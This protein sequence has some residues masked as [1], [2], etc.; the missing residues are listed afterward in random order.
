VTG[1]G[2][3][4]AAAWVFAV[5]FLWAAQSWL[6]FMT[7]ESRSYTSAFDSRV[8][9]EGSFVNDDGLTLESVV[10]THDASD[11]GYWIL[12]CPPAG[13]STRV[14]RIQGHLEQLW[15]LGYNVFAFDYRGFGGNAGTPTEEGLYAD[16]AAAYRHLVRARRVPP[17][18]IIVAGRSLGASVAV[19]LATRVEAGGLLLFSPIDSVPAVA[20]RLYPWAPVRLLARYRFDTARKA[21]TIGWP[22]L[23]V[24]GAP[25]PFI[26]LSTVRSVFDQ[27]R[28]PKRM[29]ETR[30]NHHHSGFM[31]VAQLQEA[32]AGFWPVQ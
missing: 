2:L 18:R 20:S 6:V 1:V 15:G 31:D 24:Y 11:A 26:P 8:F 13:A 10:L 5:V 9:A 12:F 21:R 3:F 4:W 29:L 7:G 19:D 23:L 17:S 16:A 14:R 27:F 32:L 25:D 28:G 30:G 22:V